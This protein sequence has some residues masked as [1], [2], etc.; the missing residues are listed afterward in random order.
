MYCNYWREKL[1]TKPS[2]KFPKKIC[3]AVAGITQ[4]FSFAYL[5]EAFVATLLAI[6]GHRSE[7]EG[8][9]DGGDDE[10]GDLDDYEL[11]REMKKQVKA[12]RED[13]DTH[14]NEAH[15]V[16]QGLEDL[17]WKEVDKEPA[18]AAVLG[19]KSAVWAPG[20]RSV[21]SK[22]AFRPG[23]GA[24][25]GPATRRQ[26]NP[27]LTGFSVDHDDKATPLISDSGM[28]VDSAYGA[29]GAKDLL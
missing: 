5:K 2:I 8:A 10:G 15:G 16:N 17:S 24:G 13:M 27:R 7:S 3:I 21:E 26:Q 28:F 19:L 6:A 20:T 12:L 22:L 4:E 1:K 11:W 25:A 9:A 29:G 23:A 14:D 18:P